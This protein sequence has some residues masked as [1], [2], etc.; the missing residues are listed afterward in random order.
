MKSNNT[1]II[2]QDNS[3]AMI[4][5]IFTCK[6]EAVISVLTERDCSSQTLTEQSRCRE[7]AACTLISRRCGS[8]N[9][10]RDSLKFVYKVARFV[11]SCFFL[12]KKSCISATSD[13]FYSHH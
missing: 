12:L 1:Q 7:R 4:S 3:C 6:L 5:S 9:D 13:F 11:T 2:S 8:T 10:P